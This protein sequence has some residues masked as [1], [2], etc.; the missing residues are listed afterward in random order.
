DEEDIKHIKPLPNLDYKILTGNSLHGFPFTSQGLLEVERLKQSFFDESDREAKAKLKS[1]IDEKLR[2]CIASS[3]KSLGHKVIFDFRTFFSEVFSSRAGFDLVIANPPYVGE[4]GHKEV[5][6]ELRT[7]VLGN[8]YQ[9]K[10]DLFY[11]FFHCALNIGNRVSHVAFITTNYYPTATGAK[12]LRTDLSKRASIMRLVN[13]N[14]LKIFE[15]AQ[16]QHNMITLLINGRDERITAETCV[17]KRTGFADFKQLESILGWHDAQTD[18]FKIPQQ[19]LYE[20]PDL[21]TRLRGFSASEGD[22]TQRLLARIKAQGELLGSVCYVNQGL[23]TGADKVTKKHFRE[24]GLDT[25]TF[26]TGEGIFVLRKT[27]L[28][29]LTLTAYERQRI[30]P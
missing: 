18:Y 27:E 1:Q 13:F 2:E 19:N 23:R 8:F 7:G 16:G 6:R 17:T 29:G 5:F 9:K 4:K 10:M 12:T 22:P 30:L 28:A 15:S 25:K 11:F 26:S 14:E 24:C 3:R 21:Q 20:G